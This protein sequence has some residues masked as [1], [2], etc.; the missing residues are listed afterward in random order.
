MYKIMCAA[1]GHCSSKR[2][3][4]IIP[5]ATKQYMT[6]DIP[7]PFRQNSN[8][9]YLCGFQEPN[10]ILVLESGEAWPSHMA[11]L[12]VPKKDP[13]KEL[14]EGARSGME[15]ATEL[16]G[17]ENAYNIEDLERY[18]QTY[19]KADQTGVV[20]YNY[21]NPSHRE[22]HVKCVETFVKKHQTGSVQNPNILIQLLR[23]LKSPAE[24][25]LMQQSCDISSEAYKKVMAY[26]HPGVSISR[27]H[28][29]LVVNKL[30]EFMF[31]KDLKCKY[32]LVFPPC[33]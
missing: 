5:S 30:L 14:W 10:S 29:N 4:V 15:G 16:T 8:F 13:H 31:T 12:F 23:V 26:S 17:V 9:V 7:Y 20:W 11:T 22:P 27:Y 25:A 21:Q 3:I 24:A 28:S 32:C 1:D 2:H 18:L 33:I 19:E 6:E